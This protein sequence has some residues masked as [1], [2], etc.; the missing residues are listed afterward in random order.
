MFL[1]VGI[2]LV[3]RIWLMLL[4]MVKLL[5]GIYIDMLVERME[6][7]MVMYL[8]Y[9]VS[10]LKLI[11][12]IY[13]LIWQV[14]IL[15]ILLDLHLHHQLHHILWLEEHF[16]WDGDLLLQKHLYLIKIKLLMLLLEYSKLLMIHW[17][18]KLV[19][20]IFS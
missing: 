17:E 8:N 7:I 6:L 19:F 11:W 5:V 20:P 15:I 14:Y 9:Q 12:L 18:N 16:K 2:L 10:L 1:L 4:M 3:L 13:L